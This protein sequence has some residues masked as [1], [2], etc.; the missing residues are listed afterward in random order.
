ML[1]GKKKTTTKN[2][3]LGKIIIQ[4]WRRD[5]EFYNQAKAGRVYDHFSGLTRNVKGDEKVITRNFKIYKRKT[6]TGKGKYKVKAVD[7]P[8][9][10]YDQGQK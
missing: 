9:K 3:L 8:F 1:K 7:Q 6:L 5:K 4:N 10:N 2:T